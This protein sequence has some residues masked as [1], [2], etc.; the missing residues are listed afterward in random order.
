[1]LILLVACSAVWGTIY[2]RNRMSSLPELRTVAIERRDLRLTVKATGT[3]E[4]EEIV[5]V[6][7]DVT[8]KIEMFGSD[9]D[10][11]DEPIDVGSR[12]TKG[13]VVVQLDRQMYEVEWQKAQAALR[14]AEAEVAGLETQLKQ[15][16]RDLERAQRLR[17]TNSQSDFDKIVTAHEAAVAELAIGRARR[18]QSIAAARQ[19]EINL[20]RTSI[21][22]PIDGVVIDRRANIGQNVGAG[23]SGLLLLA[24]NLDRMRIRASV[25]ETDIGKVIAGQPVTFTV[26][27]RRD[28]TMTG[29]VEKIM[30]N[31]RIYGNFVTYDVLVGIDSPTTMLLPHM[32][33]EVEFET[34]K[35]EQA[36][37]V[38]TNSLDWWPRHE[39]IDPAF[40]RVK[41]PA[42]FDKKTNV[43]VEGEAA[44]VWVPV[45]NGH[46]RPLQVHLGIDDGV[47]TEVIGVGIREGLPV[48]VGIV[49]ETTL[50]RIVPSVKTLH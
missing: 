1:M 16:E 10:R 33:A 43:K 22:A 49:K 29:H 18:E 48:V 20:E 36:W 45:D 21:R 23:T 26:D 3:I 35:R 44:M 15:A 42:E 47:V 40:A 31:A 46:V 30:L 17:N 19:A 38:P 25:S 14:L 11:P 34:V 41:P 37:L 6:G 32:T 8:G 24:K 39:Q 12:V 2:V 4:P 50:A 27:S 5:E 13:S 7:A 28:A 9:V